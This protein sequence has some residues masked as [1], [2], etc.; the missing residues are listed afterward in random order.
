MHCNNCGA[1]SIGKY[2]FCPNCGAYVKQQRPKR[3]EPARAVMP[4][5]EAP[6][7]EMKPERETAR[8]DSA[9]VTA[10]QSPARTFAPPLS[11]RD[12]M[13]TYAG[14]IIFMGMWLLAILI[15]FG[16]AGVYQGL[17]DR[18][19]NAIASSAEHK[20]KAKNY[21]QQGNIE[22]AIVELSE[23]RRLNP[24]DPEIATLIAQ[25]Q[26]PVPNST[27]TPAPSP[28]ISTAAQAEALNSAYA[29]ARKAYEAKDYESA[30]TA[31]ESLRRND[32]NFHK[33][34][35]EDMLYIAYVSLAHQYLS[36]KRFEE[37]VQRFDKA[38]AVR[39][40]DNLLVERNLAANYARG[41]SAR[42]ADWT[43]AI[44]AFAAVVRADPKYYDAYNLLYEARIQYGD[45]L[46]ARNAPC[47]AADQYAAAIIMGVNAEL[48]N[49]QASATAACNTV[50]SATPANPTPSF[51][52]VAT[53]VLGG[54]KYT[55]S[56][57]PGY[58]ATGD[59]EASV[60]GVVKDH[61]GRPIVG[62]ELTLF[63]NT[64]FKNVATTGIDGGYTFDGL[65]PA[66]YGVRLSEDPTS[67]SPLIYVG[68]K[69]RA[70][71]NF[72]GN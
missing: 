31:L 47:Q 30:V 68:P 48:Q 65:N 52:R 61:S 1:T 37:A 44:D 20:A 21:F 19:Q 25:L 67:S 2:D 40:S 41:L 58:V 42:G 62:M 24:K 35:V 22:L 12:H 59:P 57:Q 3:A 50:A 14:A 60:R 23:A 26:T 38:L 66:S 17:Q 69:Q 16:G 71:I 53:P 11:R 27:P 8:P 39:K 63:S 7:P 6:A 4:K 51:T 55:V 32:A 64:N 70:I 54:S 18:D 33:S 46:V 34:D 72:S 9:L 15:G 28:T 10:P 43:R 5:I 29:D 36:G 49:K 13:P 56:V 45:L